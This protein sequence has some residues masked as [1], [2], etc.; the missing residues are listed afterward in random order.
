MSAIFDISKYSRYVII[1]CEIFSE[2]HG[3]FVDMFQPV[4]PHEH[5]HSSGFYSQQYVIKEDHKNEIVHV[6]SSYFH[7]GLG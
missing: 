6:Q 2:H 1:C 7:S 3:R 4:T 5:S